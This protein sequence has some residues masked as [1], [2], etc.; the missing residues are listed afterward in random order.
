MSA[1]APVVSG[2][3][4]SPPQGLPD[5]DY[6]VPP[7]LRNLALLS[8]DASAPPG[9]EGLSSTPPGLEPCLGA[10]GMPASNDDVWKPRSCPGAIG[11]PP[12]LEM[13]APLRP[14]HKV[15]PPPVQAPVLR[16]AAS[17][18][19]TV[20]AAPLPPRTVA[21]TLLPPPPPAPPVLAS[22]EWGFD[23][24]QAEVPPPEQEA[25]SFAFGSPELP[26]VGSAEHSSGRC[27][28]CAFLFT[29][30]CENGLL[31]KFCH[32]CPPGEKKRRQK[33]KYLMHQVTGR[34]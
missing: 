4:S 31:C 17:L 14:T 7:L 25:R 26:T 11:A 9:F 2:P 1:I 12:G 28:P 21:T 27:K 20:P 29:K 34:Y 30:G 3:P 8:K 18:S 13:M 24:S 19:S 15:P 22:A 10:L 23:A 16:L 32:L 5:F 6:P 33:Q